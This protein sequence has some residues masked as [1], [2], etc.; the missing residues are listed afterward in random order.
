[1]IKRKHLIIK[2]TEVLDN[3][4]I[5]IYIENELNH[6]LEKHKIKEGDIVSITEKNHSDD[7][8]SLVI[9]YK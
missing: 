9:F 5:N 2:I 6:Y 8:Y 3:K 1:M 4:E 7:Y